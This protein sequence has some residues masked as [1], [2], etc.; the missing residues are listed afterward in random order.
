MPSD[1]CRVCWA[2]V[3]ADRT[4]GRA[5]VL[6]LLVLLRRWRGRRRGLAVP[7]GRDGLEPAVVLAT[8]AL[9]LAL[10]RVLRARVRGVVRRV[11]A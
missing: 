11:A 10:A 9:A 7:R 5:T 3:V 8:L 1:R 4:L 6:L 2:A